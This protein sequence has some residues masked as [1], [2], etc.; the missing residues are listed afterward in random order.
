MVE[1]AETEEPLT[2][3]ELLGSLRAAGGEAGTVISDQTLCMTHWGSTQKEPAS[4]GG[5]GYHRGTNTLKK[6]KI[7]QVVVCI[8]VRILTRVG[9][10]NY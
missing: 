7:T 8:E 1:S 3:H 6:M 9:H 4:L 2:L 10:L 5:E